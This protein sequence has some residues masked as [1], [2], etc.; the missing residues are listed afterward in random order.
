MASS[1]SVT[2]GVYKARER[3]H[4][5]MADRRLLAIPAS[6]RRH[7]CRPGHKGHDDLTSSSPSS[8]LSPA[9]CS[10][11]APPVSAFPKAPL[12]FKRIRGM[13]S[14]GGILNALA[15]ALHGSI[16]TTPSIHRLRLG[17]LGYLIPFAPLAFVSQCQ[18]RPSRVLS[19]LVFFPISTH[20]TAP[21]E[22]PSAPTVLQLDALRPIIPDNACILCLTAA[23][24]TELADAYSPDT[25]IA[26]SPGKEE[27]GPCLSPS[28]ADHPLGPATDHRLGKLL[29]HQLANQTRAPPR[30]D[31]SFCSSAYGVLAAVSSCCSPP[32]GRFLR[33]THPS[34]TGNTTSRPT[35]MYK[36]DS[37]FSCIPRRNLYPCA[38]YSP[39]VRS[40]KYSPPARPSIPLASYT[41]SILIRSRHQNRKT[42]IGFRGNQARTDDFHRVKVTLYR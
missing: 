19:P 33:V 27:S 1:H 13:S 41:L 10:G 34:A 16:R 38:S 23:A 29:P 20:F 22:I 12:S 37:E 35:C 17:L 9:V 26:S 5:R 31:S 40:Q 21:P 6:C 30:A 18:C 11:H 28:V 8:G 32:K 14:P 42:H 3:I 2:G 4:R 39:G 36:A 25:V 7:V 15:T 24:G